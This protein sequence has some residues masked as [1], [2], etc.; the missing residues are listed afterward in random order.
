VLDP[1]I[2]YRKSARGVDAI[3]TRQAALAPRPRAL[4]ILVDGKRSCQQLAALGAALGDTLELMEGLLA[5]GYVEPGPLRAVGMAPITVAARPAP[6]NTPIGPTELRVPL[7][8][9]RTFAV[10]RLSDL[11]GPA[12]TDLCRRIE[13]ARSAHEFRAAVRRTETSLREVVGPELTAQFVR[14]VENLR[15]N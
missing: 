10:A 13:G 9:A 14:E 3:A 7:E 6:R 11:L 15:A 1:A 12:G 4:L 8:Q 5:Q 2:I